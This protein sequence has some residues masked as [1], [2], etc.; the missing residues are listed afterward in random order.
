MLKVIDYEFV[1]NLQEY[2]S[3]GFYVY[4]AGHHGK[5]VA[6]LIS[7][8]KWDFISFVETFPK[9]KG[10][11]ECIAIQ[12]LKPKR[13]S[14]VIVASNAYHHEIMS[15]IKCYLE[16]CTLVISFYAF[17][18]ALYIHRE[19]SFISEEVYR[20]LIRNYELFRL[21]LPIDYANYFS[22]MY[23]DAVT[24]EFPLILTPG[25]VGS[26]T[27]CESLNN[28]AVHLHS[29]VL[30]YSFETTNKETFKEEQQRMLEKSIKIITAVRNPYDRDISAFLQNTE[31]DV[32]P[33]YRENATAFLWYDDYLNNGKKYGEVY[34]SRFKSWKN[35]IS[36]AC[37]NYL[38]TIVDQQCDEFS[39]F[40]YEIK[41]YFGIDVFQQQ[42]DKSKGYKIY[43]NR[44]IELLLIKI[45]K[46]QDIADIINQFVGGNGF[47]I[48]NSNEGN[49]KIYSYLYQDIKKH[50]KLP[51]SYYRYYL[52]DSKR[53]NF[54]SVEELKCASEKY[55]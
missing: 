36:E 6:R 17:M 16:E 12:D 8:L 43:K 54:Y 50:I 33:W 24:S 3:S 13:E 45:E 4:G 30:P 35:S 48:V 49:S 11:G 22:R 18:M 39:W 26:R 53:L 44:G 21:T 52:Q 32:W 37:V 55:L 41:S 38:N 40:D 34:M 1:E 27:I 7:L 31:K 28:K 10:S 5:E 9:E 23:K 47:E 2:I 25:K 46:I 29:M 19:K 20:E 51:E 15:K 14:I 42:F